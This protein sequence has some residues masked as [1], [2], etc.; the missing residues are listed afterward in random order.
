MQ[1]TQT[2]NAANCPLLIPPTALPLISPLS[3]QRIPVGHRGWVHTGRDSAPLT[4]DNTIRRGFLLKRQVDEQM[5]GRMSWKA[6]RPRTI[7][8]ILRSR[9]RHWMIFI[10]QRSCPRH[11]QLHR[12][13]RPHIQLVPEP[14]SRRCGRTVVSDP[15][16]D[17]AH[18]HMTVMHQ[19]P[20][21][22][23]QLTS[24]Q[25]ISLDHSAKRIPV[26]SRYQ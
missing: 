7:R 20:Q 19:H 8:Y 25:Q 11:G 2:N 12:E 13:T 24:A 10:A 23:A 16:T 6:S 3:R 14:P 26:G 22:Q 15:P 21:A 17:D 18:Y 9:L 5:S 4:C 1:S